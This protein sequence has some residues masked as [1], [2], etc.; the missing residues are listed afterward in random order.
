LN[1]ISPILNMA[2]SKV[3]KSQTTPEQAAQEAISELE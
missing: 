3:I 1:K 2:V